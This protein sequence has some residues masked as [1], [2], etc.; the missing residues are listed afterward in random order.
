MDKHYELDRIVA[1]DK[2]VLNSLAACG[3]LED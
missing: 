1:L 2:E 3:D